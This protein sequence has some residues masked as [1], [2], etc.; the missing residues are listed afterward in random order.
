VH[1]DLNT[2]ATLVTLAVIIV[3]AVAAFVQLRHL[4]ASNQLQGLLTVLARVESADFGRL[5]DGA[6][7]LLAEKLADP[8]YRRSIEDATVDRTNNPWLNL[9]NSYEWVGSLVRRGLIEEEPYMDIYADR[10]IAAWEITRDAIAIVRRR[11]GPSPLE[12]FEY[13]Y[14]RASEYVARHPGGVYPAH[15]PRAQLQDPWAERDAPAAPAK[16]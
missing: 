15:V 8:A 13:L 7:Q 12:N 4:R 9:C 1:F 5:V 14:V 10:V 6:R 16:T 3:T 2:A 11:G